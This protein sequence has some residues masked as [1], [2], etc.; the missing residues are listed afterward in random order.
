MKQN[1]HLWHGLSGRKVPLFWGEKMSSEI[2]RKWISL[3]AGKQTADPE[4]NEWYLGLDENL[5][6]AD[7]RRV[8]L[9]HI[10]R[11][12]SLLC[13]EGETRKLS[14]NFAKAGSAIQEAILR[15]IEDFVQRKSTE[16]DSTR[17]S[18]V[19][20]MLPLL[21]AK[22]KKGSGLFILPRLAKIVGGRS[23]AHSLLSRFLADGEIPEECETALKEML[24]RDPGAAQIRALAAEQNVQEGALPP[25][26]VTSL[27]SSYCVPGEWLSIVESYL[28]ANPHFRQSLLSSAIFTLKDK[29]STKDLTGTLVRVLIVGTRAEDEGDKQL[30]Y[31]AF[32]RLKKGRTAFLQAVPLALVEELLLWGLTSNPHLS[33]ALVAV[34]D[35]HPLS[36]RVLQLIPMATERTVNRKGVR[37]GLVAL[38]R[39]RYSDASGHATAI[40]RYLAL[41]AGTPREE[42]RLLLEALNHSPVAVALCLRNA[43]PERQQQILEGL[44][45]GRVAKSNLRLLTALLDTAVDEPLIRHILGL[46]SSPPAVVVLRLLRLAAAGCLGLDGVVA[47][48]NALSFAEKTVTHLPH[49]IDT[50]SV[51]RIVDKLCIELPALTVNPG[52]EFLQ[53]LGNL[54]TAV[55]RLVA[56]VAPLQTL[57]RMTAENVF[58]GLVTR[59][60]DEGTEGK[61]AALAALRTQMIRE[62]EGYIAGILESLTELPGDENECLPEAISILFDTVKASVQMATTKIKDLVAV[63]KSEKFSSSAKSST[64]N[65]WFNLCQD[66]ADLEAQIR[67]FRSRAA[68]IVADAVS[69]Q[70]ENVCVYY[71]TYS[72]VPAG[73]LGRFNRLFAS[74]GVLSADGD[75]RALPFEPS[76]HQM[77]PGAVVPAGT[78]VTVVCPGLHLHDGTA[79]SKTLVKRESEEH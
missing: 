6:K 65:A 18:V 32:W 30:A 54:F 56:A 26:E 67:L 62:S 21:I 60:L 78:E 16:R 27:M 38:H 71:G 10:A 73:L 37:S 70:F 17:Q 53:E 59:I 52:L 64:E 74:A 45:I 25:D 13:K 34:S 7:R 79:L 41:Q 2:L 75:A 51:V 61:Q 12:T 46:A 29:T 3:L 50:D 43:A 69:H 44:S 9:Q 55:T 28:R 5:S 19:N 11:Q 40:N 39:N 14:Q 47:K 68:R 20:E 77:E 23:A 57:K 24:A 8:V 42:K 36:D 49:M 22:A 33:S 63:G 58:G 48:D 76:D 72:R 66:V 15:G 1:S 4:M 35:V 31:S